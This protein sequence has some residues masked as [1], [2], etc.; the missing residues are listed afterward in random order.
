MAQAQMEA[1]FPNALALGADPVVFKW[2]AFCRIIVAQPID[3][4]RKGRHRQIKA[5]EAL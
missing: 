1:E 5:K 4:A 2:P 3:K